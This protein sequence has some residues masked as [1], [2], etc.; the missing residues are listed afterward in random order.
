LLSLTPVQAS[1][2]DIS[3]AAIRRAQERF[4]PAAT[5]VRWLVADVLSAE[6][7]D[8][9]DLWHDRAMFHF[10]TR[11]EDRRQYAAIAAKT[12]VE[13]GH[14]IIATFAPTGPDKC[15]GLPTCRFDA[16]SLSQQ[17]A[18]WFELVCST[19]ERH[20]TP[21]QRNQDFTYVVL[22]RTDLAQEI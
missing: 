20:T 11:L 15:S 7:L 14:A 8:P 22:K 2:L 18:P 19:A 10:L 6:D 3:P 16:L 17:F 21:W 9:V 13:Q 5:S 1:V 4:G 12:V